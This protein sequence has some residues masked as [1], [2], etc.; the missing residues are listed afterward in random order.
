MK[1]SIL[2]LSLAL[3]ALLLGCGGEEEEEENPA[4]Y[5]NTQLLGAV[6]DETLAGFVNALETN[7]T[8]ESTSRAP[9]LMSP[10]EGGSVAADSVLEWHIGAM[11]RATSESAKAIPAHGTPYSGFAT[12]LEILPDGSDTPALQVFTSDV[13]YTLTSADI[14]A[15]KAAGSSFTLHLLGADFESDRVIPDGGPYEGS[16]TTITVQE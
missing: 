2:P 11:D 12:Y 16:S 1:T 14:D 15:L 5:E 6:T 3:S 10:S 7:G 13:S 8:L 4:G 9:T